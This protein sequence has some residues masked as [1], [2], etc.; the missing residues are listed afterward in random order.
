MV[1]PVDL[2]QRAVKTL[3]V[4]CKHHAEASPGAHLCSS[5]NL[6]DLVTGTPETSPCSVQRGSGYGPHS[7]S[8]G[9][10]GHWF[11]KKDQNEKTN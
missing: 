2:G 4:N 9:P 5:P 1:G 7:D 3:C 10:D 8:C 6:Y 11:G